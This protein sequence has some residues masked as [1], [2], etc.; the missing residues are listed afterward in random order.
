[1][2]SRTPAPDLTERTTTERRASPRLEIVLPVAV[3]ILVE[4]ETFSPAHHLG[5]TRN[6]SETGVLIE[7][8]DI[9]EVQYRHFMRKQRMIRIHVQGLQ[10][11]RVLFGRIV[12]YD[13]RLTSRGGRLLIGVAFDK[14]SSEDRTA[15][16]ALLR[17][18]NDRSSS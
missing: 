14:L 13:Y 16:A 1:M 5:C 17:G 15:I 12:W 18:G 3:R 7:I 10:A 9:R 2:L 4:E 6:M 11:N 8:P